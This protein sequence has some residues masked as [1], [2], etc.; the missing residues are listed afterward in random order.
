M[1]ITLSGQV[2]ALAAQIG[3]DV[4]QLVANI[5]DLSS[6]TTTQ[7]ASLV[8]ALNELKA[9]LTSLE[10]QLG[11]QIND[12]STATTTTWSSHK[13]TTQISD[14]VSA[15]VNGA[16]DAL[17]TLKELADAIETN[18]D[19]IS[20]LQSIAAGHVKFSEAQSLD[21]SQ[22]AQARTN[23]SAASTADITTVEG[24]IGTLASLETT[25]KTSAVAA[26]NEVK[27]LADAAQSAADAAKTTANG[28][29]SAAATAQGTAQAAQTTASN[30]QTAVNS[31]TTAVGETTT[32]FVT[33]YTTAR[34]GSA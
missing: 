8:V 25:D 10:S 5:G 2:S 33:I 16:P 31:L 34:D 30:A 12:E 6:L 24:H 15:L 19:A 14:A 17:D 28:A 26:I 11:A 29:Q 22:K 4:K 32:D 7:K 3:T 1:A 9:G 23:I 18:Q 27:A 20:A 21:D 13:I